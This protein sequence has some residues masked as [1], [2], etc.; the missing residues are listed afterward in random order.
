ME[1]PCIFNT[2]NH[3]PTPSKSLTTPSPLKL[4]A[5]PYWGLNNRKGYGEISCSE[6]FTAFKR[7]LTKHIL[8]KGTQ[9]LEELTGNG[10]SQTK[11][12]YIFILRD[13]ISFS[14]CSTLECLHMKS[15]NLGLHPQHS[16]YHHESASQL[17][18]REPYP[19]LTVL[20]NRYSHLG[21]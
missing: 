17:C 15:S 8:T 11:W 3:L 20:S 13:V 5:L 12:T 2:L 18:Y 1:S 14:F 7:H 6:N 19:T 21:A 16:C 10:T 9:Q 4:V